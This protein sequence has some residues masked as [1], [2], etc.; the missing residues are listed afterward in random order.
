MMRE[1]LAV[2]PSSGD[3]E[4]E[5]LVFCW[6]ATKKKLASSTCWASCFGRCH[7]LRDHGG[8]NTS[9]RQFE[10]RRGSTP[11]LSYLREARPGAHGAPSSQTLRSVAPRPNTHP[12]PVPTK[13]QKKRCLCAFILTGKKYKKEEN[14]KEGRGKS[15]ASLTGVTRE[16]TT[17]RSATARPRRTEDRRTS[18]AGEV[19]RRR[20]IHP[21]DRTRTS[22]SARGYVRGDVP[23]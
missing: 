15:H 9:A 10:G 22:G 11:R 12:P 19:R 21:G 5:E 3:R 7:P 14:K 6:H 1:I 16:N 23:R 18:L 4:G 8:H 2:T 17:S 13:K 20:G